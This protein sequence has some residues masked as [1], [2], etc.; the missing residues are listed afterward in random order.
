[1]RFVP[2]KNAQQ[3]RNMTRY[4]VRRKVSRTGINWDIDAGDLIAYAGSK[5]LVVITAAH[6]YK[7]SSGG[8]NADE[9]YT[10]LWVGSMEG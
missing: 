7:S 9:T 1:M 4:L 8:G 10:R 3:L 5:D 2:F 6:V